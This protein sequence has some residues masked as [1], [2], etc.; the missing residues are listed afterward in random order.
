MRNSY[1]GKTN[2]GNSNVGK[3]Y[4]GKSHT[5]NN[6]STYNNLTNIDSTKI[7]VVVVQALLNNN[8]RHILIVMYSTFTKKM[9]LE[10][11]NHSLLI[12]LMHG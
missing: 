7:T 3:T 8:H 10:Y 4:V 6:N 11:Y 2:V 12:K 5:T 9:D 1:V